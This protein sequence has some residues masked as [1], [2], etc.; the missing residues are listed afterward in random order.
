LRFNYRCGSRIVTASQYALGEDREYEA[1]ETAHEGTIFFHPMTVDFDQQA[2]Y[3]FSTIL[4]AALKRMP[5]VAPGKIAIL[6]PA[7]WIGDKVANAAQR[8]GIEIVR[9]DNNALY[10]RSSGLLR[11]L[12]LCAAWCC[13]GWR[14][15]EPRFSKLTAEGVRIFAEVLVDEERKTGFRR[16]L[17][18]LLWDTRNEAI[19]LHTWLQQFRDELLHDLIKRC[20]TLDDEGVL[21]AGLVERT[22]DGNDAAGL[23]LGR[24]CGSGDGNDRINLSTLHSSKGRE[25]ALVVLFAMNNGL[26]PRSVGNMVEARRLFYVGFTRAER[27]LHM[28]FSKTGPSPFVTEVKKRIEAD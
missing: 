3:L 21:L 16:K 20:R 6:Y 2:E 26:I 4:P 5:S 7:A 25:F 22:K 28:M 12:E 19:N 24:F 10:P 8:Y 18:G 1:P 27:E 17:L 14:T 13:N 9:A 11:W 23:T 15:G